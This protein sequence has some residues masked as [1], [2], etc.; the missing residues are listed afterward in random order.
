M[1]KQDIL[2]YLYNRPA[3]F[4]NMDNVVTKEVIS[5]LTSMTNWWQEVVSVED[6]NA[7]AN[8]KRFLTFKNWYWDDIYHFYEDE[9]V[10]V[11]DII[12]TVSSMEEVWEALLR[13]ALLHEKPNNAYD[14]VEYVVC[15]SIEIELNTLINEIKRLFK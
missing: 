7:V 14:A 4:N 9:M 11:D 5:Y 6:L 2:K 13:E 12:Q 1:K 3:K 15:K 8:V 10:D